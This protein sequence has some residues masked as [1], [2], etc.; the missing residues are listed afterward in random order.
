MAQ[1]ES[2][3]ALSNCFELIYIVYSYANR[4]TGTESKCTNL[5]SYNYLG[6]AESSGPCAESA[7]AAITKYGI[8]LCS[9][10][11]ELG[12]II[13]TLFS[14]HIPLSLIGNLYRS[15]DINIILMQILI[16]AVDS[17]YWVLEYYDVL[18]HFPT[19]R[20][21]PLDFKFG[22]LSKMVD[23]RFKDVDINELLSAVDLGLHCHLFV[24]SGTT[25]EQV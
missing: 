7:K 10:R 2:W 18:W 17:P 19:H 25:P 8:A 23:S 21:W 24:T 14:I 15:V 5:A 12:Q 4:F 13:R 1:F 11:Q 22:V 3:T 16:F 9:S 6:F 20:K